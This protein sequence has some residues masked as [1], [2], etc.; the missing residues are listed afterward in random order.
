MNLWKALIFDKMVRNHLL[1]LYMHGWDCNVNSLAYNRVYFR[2]LNLYKYDEGL[3]GL[4]WS[5]FLLQQVFLL[6]NVEAESEECREFL[7]WCENGGLKLPIVGDAGNVDLPPPKRDEDGSVAKDFMSIIFGSES[8][9]TLIVSEEEEDE[10]EE[11]EEDEEEVKRKEQDGLAAIGEAV[12]CLKLEMEEKEA[13]EELEE[14]E[15]V[16]EDVEASMEPSMKEDEGLGMG[17]ESLGEEEEERCVSVDLQSGIDGSSEIEKFIKAVTFYVPCTFWQLWS[18]DSIMELLKKPVLLGSLVFLVRMVSD[19]VQL[20]EIRDAMVVQ[21]KL[22]GQMVPSGKASFL[23]GIYEEEVFGMQQKMG[24]R[25]FFPRDEYPMLR[26]VNLGE[27][28]MLS[29]LWEELDFRPS[30]NCQW[31]GNRMYVWGF[32]NWDF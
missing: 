5:R 20:A 4:K 14:G 21:A 24:L 17:M 11:G 31:L 27:Y 23:F 25:D 7:R 1:P 15:I 8:D 10:E 32:E 16:D 22:E 13:K 26:P 19:L 30:F 6:R 9:D 18:R 28:K 2:L 29:A 3:N 12:E